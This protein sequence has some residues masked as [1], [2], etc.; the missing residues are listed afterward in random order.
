[1]LSLSSNCIRW[2]PLTLPLSTTAP[3]CA[4]EPGCLPISAQVQDC[5][6]AH[7]CSRPSHTAF[8]SRH[9][10][11]RENV[12]F[13]PHPQ[14]DVVQGIWRTLG[15]LIP[16]LLLDEWQSFSTHAIVLPHA[17]PIGACRQYC[18]K[19]SQYLSEAAASAAGRSPNGGPGQ[20]PPRKH[21]KQVCTARNKEKW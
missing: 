7:L 1:M 6:C 20:L 12:A 18:V 11:P 8:G 16:P 13:R 17:R 19:R 15:G 14:A 21:V 4:E 9:D 3:L 5:C 2:L 10:V